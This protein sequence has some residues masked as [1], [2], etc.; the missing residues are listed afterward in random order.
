MQEFKRLFVPGIIGN[1]EIRNRTIMSPMLKNYGNRNGTV[2]QR[3]ID[4]FA[5]RAKGGIGLILAEAVYVSP[6]SKGNKF[7]LGIHDDLVIEG[8]K[9]LTEAVQQYGAKI[10]LEIQHRGQ[11]TSSVFSYLQPVSP[12]VVEYKA[13]L[14][15]GFRAKGDTSRALT[16]LEIKDLIKKFANAAVRTKKAGMDL[17]EVHGGH[18]YLINEFF[19]PYTNKR[20]DEYGGTFEKRCR[21]P[22]EVIEAVRKAVGKDYPISYRITGDEYVDGGL[23]IDDVVRFAPMLEEAGIDLIDVSGGIHETIYMIVPPMDIPLGCH[24][25]LAAA[26]KQVVNIPVA[27]V[28]RINDPVQADTI[29]LEN[30]A[31][32]I[33]FGR[34]VHADPE[35]LNKA[36]EGRL[37]EIR[38]CLACNEG[39]IDTLTTRSPITCVVNA[40]AGKE[41]EYE[42]M[43]AARKKKVV[44]IGGGPGGMEAARV[45]SLRGHEVILY[46]KAD[47]LG[48]Q[49]NIA[50][51]APNMDGIEDSI[52][53]LSTQMNKL[54]VTLNLGVEATSDLI[55]SLKP[56]AVVVAT[57][58][59]PFK[60]LI[61][62]IEQKHVYTS[63]ELFEGKAKI[64]KKA[65][66]LGG[67]LITCEAALFLRKKGVEV[68]IVNPEVDFAMTEGTRTIWCL[69]QPIKEDKNI[70]IF[71]RSTIQK[72]NPNSVIIQIDGEFKEIN[73][74][75]SIIISVGNISCNEVGDALI[76]NRKIPEVYKIGDCLEPRKQKDAIHEG[77]VAGLRI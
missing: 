2:G 42:I 58:G 53:Y 39:C 44:V 74:V 69:L 56:D 43:K 35:F 68:V 45:A 61:P 47:K 27:V 64:G 49:I 75:D 73:G 54:G 26:I 19:S 18:G 14:E 37:D 33:V 76:L 24:V 38:N 7:Q 32:F 25:H 13:S 34:A 55:E 12:S 16:I 63:W 48:G 9:K 36:R 51:R 10:A 57:G 22:L 21:F 72:I 65:V 3:Y 41:N 59:I 31:D 28:G 62:G 60:P 29:L 17:V 1:L 46:E 66:I 20:T 8:Y 5:A 11:E 67:D 6:E 71:N 4:Y 15:S 50:K 70:S 40:A 23:T 77:F 30:K 52:R